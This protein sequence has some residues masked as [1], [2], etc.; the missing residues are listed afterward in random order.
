M[1]TDTLIS[2]SQQRWGVVSLLAWCIWCW[3]NIKQAVVQ[4]LLLLEN[5]ICDPHTL[6]CDF[7]F[8][9]VETITKI[10]EV[11]ID[12]WSAWNRWH[13][14]LVP[15]HDYNRFHS[16]TLG[17]FKSEA[18]PKRDIQKND[19]LQFFQ[20]QIIFTHLKL[21][22]ASARHSFTWVKTKIAYLSDWRVKLLT[23][24]LIRLIRTASRVR[25]AVTLSHLVVF[26]QG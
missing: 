12:I 1:L 6:N 17:H 24:R 26:A 8:L 20:I 25:P 22:I 18:C 15:N 3:H 19:W 11:N 14:P 23:E 13:D 16:K 21:R 7:T 9:R 2:P 4:R 5:Y 10:R